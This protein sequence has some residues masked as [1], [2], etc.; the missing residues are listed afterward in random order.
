[1]GERQGSDG[2]DLSLGTRESGTAPRYHRNVIPCVSS[3]NRQWTVCAMLQS[4]PNP[5]HIKCLIKLLCNQTWITTGG[6]NWLQ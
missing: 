2:F 4:N 3:L 6:N 5:M 1:M